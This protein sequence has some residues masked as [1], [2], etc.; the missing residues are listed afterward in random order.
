MIEKK[1]RI[2]VWHNLPSGG[3]KRA[4]WDHVS[5]LLRLG[6]QVE[7]WCPEMADKNY[8]PL[9][10]LCREHRL[11]LALTPPP[12]AVKFF[13]WIALD[14]Q[15][16]ARIVAM[17]AHCA[18]AAAEINRGNFDIVLAN[19]CLEMLASPL[20]RFLQAPKVL[21][22][23]EPNRRF[24]EALEESPWAAPTGDP[25]LARLSVNSLR[26]QH[27]RLLMREE[28]DNAR[29]YDRILANSFY[30]RESILRAYGLDAD[31]CYLGVDTDFF[32]P[33]NEPVEKYVIGLGSLIR[34][35][36]AH[37]AIQA[38]GLIPAAQRPKLL[39]IGN[40]SGDI[41]AAELTATAKKA[42]VEFEVK[43]MVKDAELISDLSRATAMIY[44]S[45]LEPFG[46]APLEAN[47][48]GTP[49]IALAEGGVR[50]TIVPGENGLLAANARPATLA[51][52][53]LKLITDPMLAAQLRSRCRAVVLA[54]W[55]SSAAAERLEAALRDTLATVAPAK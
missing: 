25:S 34:H 28:L 3:A 16:R 29:H 10:Q 54:R 47:A 37:L 45:R 6:H 51:A 18:A 44:S 1:M 50:E 35:K 4:L 23:Q 48:C 42:G 14:R 24:Y 20:A 40:Y 36:G 15:V 55:Q 11:P 5:G 31:V 17:R 30:S 53:L 21:Y 8:L 52:T 13:G 46:L 38:L 49:V 26:G 19:S 33:T 27:R 39:W 2:A 12:A 9:G 22:L 7:S 41:S 43:I 32:R